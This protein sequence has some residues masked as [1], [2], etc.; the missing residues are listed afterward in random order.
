[1]FDVEFESHDAVNALT[2]MERQDVALHVLVIQLVTHAQL[3]AIG[4]DTTPSANDRE[5]LLLFA[6]GL[7][8]MGDA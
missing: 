4:V 5:N 8:V 1:M 6:A 7:T 3:T 2:P